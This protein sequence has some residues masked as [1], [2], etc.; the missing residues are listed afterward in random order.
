MMLLDRANET[1]SWHPAP[2]TARIHL[3]TTFGHQLGDVLV[4]ERIPGTPATHKTITSPG[5]WRPL[6][7]LCGLIGMEFH[8]IKD[9]SSQVRNGTRKLHYGVGSIA[10]FVFRT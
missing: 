8:P 10:K 5:Y 1:T 9:A 4:G 7:G 6:N 3:D 2:N